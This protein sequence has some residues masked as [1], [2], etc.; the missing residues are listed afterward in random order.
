ML[1][2]DSDYMEGCHPAIL[3][4]LQEINLD[5]NVGY[6]LDPYCESARAK[7]LEACKCPDAQVRLLVGG[8]QTNMLVID[9]MLRSNEGVIATT[10]GHIN[11]H[12]S[13]AIEGCGHKVIPVKGVNGKY[14]MAA[15]K[16]W[17]EAFY[18][19]TTEVGFEHYVMPR[20]IYLS[21][22]TE[23]GTIYS[24]AELEQLRAI[25]D[26]Y[27][28]YLYMDGA[29]LGYGLAAP[30]NDLTLPDIARLCDAFYIGGTKVGALMGEAVVVTNPGIEL[31]RGLIKH[32]GAML[33]KGWLLGVQFDT[34]MTGG[35]YMDISKNAVDQ[36]LRLRQAMEQ[37]GYKV[38]IDSPTNQ[39]FFVLDNEKMAQL[40]Q[41]VK[42]DYI[43]PADATHSVVRFATSWATTT[44]QVDNLMA[45]L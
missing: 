14:D 16:Q 7:I 29:R 34:L 20:A 30:G 4:K 6:G 5:K 27:G 42:F 36:A 11:V 18:E 41:H 8:T 2:F 28:F 3:Q 38:Y 32:R 22:P 37:K 13:G 1:R 33:A 21:N 40:S 26:Q 19:E 17:L 44:E 31:T 43:T 10:T 45:L 23:L 39:Q 12:E 25:C 9:A 15:L 35:L 24:L